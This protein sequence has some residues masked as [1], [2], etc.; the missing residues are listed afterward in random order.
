MEGTIDN[1]AKTIT[2]ELPEGSTKRFAPQITISEFAVVEPAS[3]V[4]QDFTEPVPYTVTAQNGDTRTYKVIV[5][6]STQRRENPD[7]SDYQAK[8]GTIINK[9]RE[10][11]EDDWEWMQL[12]IY[13]ICRRTTDRTLTT[14]L[15]LPKRL[16]T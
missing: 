13:E 12:G 15:I 3:G 8:L 7:K 11:A 5:T 2:L 14:G 9:Y 16:K 4:L 1:D 6:V 10:S